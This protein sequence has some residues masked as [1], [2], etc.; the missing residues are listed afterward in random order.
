VT[1]GVIK[2]TTTGVPADAP[3]PLPGETPWISGQQQPVQEGVYRRLTLAGSTRYSYFDGEHWLW[4]SATPALAVRVPSSDLSLV[5][6]SPWAGLIMP[7]PQGYG[8]MPT[9]PVEEADTT[10]GAPC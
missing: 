4:N 10:T 9:N 1:A 8:P 2:L 3:C 5:Q 7:P 6:Q